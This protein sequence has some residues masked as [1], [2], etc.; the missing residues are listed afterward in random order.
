VDGDKGEVKK[1]EVA[2]VEVENVEVSRGGRN[3]KIKK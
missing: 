1:M 3:L 2:K